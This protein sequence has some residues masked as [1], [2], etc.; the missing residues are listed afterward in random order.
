[1]QKISGNPGLGLL[2]PTQFAKYE[3]NIIM[4]CLES[5]SFVCLFY[6]YLST[7]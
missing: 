2:S 7:M 3:N 1:M 4:Y 6:V 5:V